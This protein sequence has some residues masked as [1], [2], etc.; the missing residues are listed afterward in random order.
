MHNT[1]MKNPTI[2]SIYQIDAFTDRPFSGNPA[3]VCP[4]DHWYEDD[5]L[6]QIAS[7]NNLSET[8]YFVMENDGYRLRWF[9]PTIEVQ[10]CGHATLASAWVLFNQLNYPH[11]S[12]TFFTLS[13]EL[14]V[15]KEDDGWL[16]MDFPSK[17]T[18][19]IHEPN[20][21]F[22]ALG[23]KPDQVKQI[24][25]SDDILIEVEHEDIVKDLN[26]NF[27]KLIQIPTRGIIVT[28]K[29]K[30]F[31]FISRW[32][33]PNVGVNED[34]VTGSAHTTLIPYWIKQIEKPIFLIQQGGS[35]KGQLKASLSTNQQR[36]YL[37]GQAC[38]VMQGKLIISI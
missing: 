10:L 19:I 21:L 7:E 28:S 5:L 9:T 34:P 36:V 20:G 2:I 38:L 37:Y 26:P 12:I 22:S 4:L 14:I 1:S 35:R 31:D 6:Q 23:L 24:C 15:T 18:S 8:A 32:F 33:G 3:A 17:S 29:S 27:N 11:K 16:R 25:K 30:K 13:G